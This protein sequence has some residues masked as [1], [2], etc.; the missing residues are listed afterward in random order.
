MTGHYIED[1]LPPSILP[2]ERVPPAWGGI[3]LTWIGWMPPITRFLCANND[4]RKTELCQNC[5]HAW[6]PYSN[7]GHT[8][9]WRLTISLERCGFCGYTTAETQVN[10]EPAQD[11]ILD[12]TDYEEDDGWWQ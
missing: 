9:N 5:R 12:E 3:Q 4:L 10:G 11:W 2:D 7:Q 1:E 8:S 6:L